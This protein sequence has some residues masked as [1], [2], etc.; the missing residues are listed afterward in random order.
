MKPFLWQVPCSGTFPSVVEL[1]HCCQSLLEG[2]M[3]MLKK[4]EA[5]P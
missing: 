4:E 2:G 1:R 3:E 5:G